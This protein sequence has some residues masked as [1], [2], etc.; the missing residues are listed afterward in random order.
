[1]KTGYPQMKY[2]HVFFDLDHTLWDFETNSKE[3]L[4]DLYHELQLH[5]AGIPEFEHFHSTYHHH[6]TIFWDRFRKGYITREE[7]RW[8]RMWRTLLEY[9]VT[10]EKLARALSERYLEILPTKKNLFNDTMEILDYLKGKG[11]PMHLITNGFEKTQYA[12]VR[13]SGLE[14]YFTHIITSEAA[15]IMKPHVAIFEYAV[16][17]AGTTASDSIM[18]G[19]TL[20]A[21]IEG[22]NNAGM[23]TV[24]FNPLVPASGKII[25]TFVINTLR[26][27]KTI[28]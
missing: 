5:N 13:N 19:D 25:P 24:Y 23:D 18:I 15:G 1:M 8:K 17:V 4:Y 16:K 12:K 21:D 26:E 10:N 7:L 28:L 2:Q 11:Y 6:N 20:D 27:L 14:P 3:T 22:G 9:K